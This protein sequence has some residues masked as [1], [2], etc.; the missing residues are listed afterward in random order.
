[1]VRAVDFT[2]RNGDC[3]FG[4]AY[5]R[6][7]HLSGIAGNL[8]MLGNSANVGEKSSGQGICVVREI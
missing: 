7:Y 1:M 4:G 2:Q 6:V 3:F 8:E 5:D